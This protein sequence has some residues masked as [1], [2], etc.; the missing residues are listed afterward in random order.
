[1]PSDDKKAAKKVDDG[2][3][4][5]EVISKSPNLEIAQLRFLVNHP[6]LDP[7]LKTTNLEQLMGE[8]KANDMAPFYKLLAEEMLAS[9]R[10][11]S[12]AKGLL[13]GSGRGGPVFLRLVSS[14]R[15]EKTNWKQNVVYLYQFPKTPYLPNPSPFCLKIE[16]YLRANNLKYEVISSFTARSEKGKL[17]FIELNG[18]QVSDSQ[19]IIWHLQKQFQVEDSLKGEQRGV[20]RAIDRML[21][22]ST[23]NCLNHERMVNKAH[24]TLARNVS[25]LPLPGFITNILAKRFAKGS[26]SNINK[27]MDRLSG[28]E[29]KEVLKRDVQA[30]DDVLADKKFLFGD[31]MTVADC[32]T[33]GHLATAYYLPFRQ[34]ITDLLDEEHPRLKDYLNRIRA[35]YWQ[36]WKLPEY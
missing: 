33:F 4:D 5:K 17:P 3:Y 27:K 19:I 9:Q 36:D 18:E 35:H 26:Q 25:G 31:R 13:V 29:L 21:D 8:I 10:I 2:N 22:M 6:E 14:K 28:D 16:T 34:P 23:V 12:T 20:A 1:M 7:T 15:V 24:L 11:G 30:L 32:T